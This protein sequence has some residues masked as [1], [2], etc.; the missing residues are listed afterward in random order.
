MTAP[1][2]GKIVVDHKTK[3][4]VRCGRAVSLGYSGGRDNYFK[5][6]MA[7]LESQAGLTLTELEN[8][9]WP[10]GCGKTSLPV[11]IHHLNKKLAHVYLHVLDYRPLAVKLTRRGKR[12]EKTYALVLTRAK[13]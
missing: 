10:A 12:P 2:H 11:T 4:V 3:I 13:F 1:E 6:F 9:V 8:K 7:L 5:T